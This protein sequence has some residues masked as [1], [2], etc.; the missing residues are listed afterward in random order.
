LSNPYPQANPHQPGYPQ[1]PGYSP[2]QPQQPAYPQAQAQVNPYAQANPYAQ[3]SPYTGHQNLDGLYYIRLIKHTGALILWH[4]QTVAVTGTLEQC[5][6]AYKSAQT[7]CLAAGWWSMASA[8]VMNWIALFSNMSAIKKVR[9]MAHG[10]GYGPS[11]GAQPGGA[12][13]TG[14]P[15]A[16][17]PAGAAPALQSGPQA[18]AVAPV[19]PRS[20]PQGPAPGWYPS[21][22]GPG[23]RYWDGAA[24]TQWTNPPGRG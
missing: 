2:A 6:A 1:Q 24:W 4:Q 9:A 17:G 16:A 21:P 20:A 14:A 23:Q 3:G 18:P 5:E 13:P 11:T 8:L 7:H 15:H 12:Q 22:S 19:S 10:D